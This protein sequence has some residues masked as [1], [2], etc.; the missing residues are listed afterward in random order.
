MVKLHVLRNGSP[1]QFYYLEVEKKEKKAPDRCFLRVPIN[2]ALNIND[3][4][5]VRTDEATPTYLFAGKIYEVQ[6][7]YGV[8]EATAYSYGIKADEIRV[9]PAKIYRNTSPESIARDLVT[10]FLGMQWGSTWSSGVTISS[11][12]AMGTVGENIR[13]LARMAGADYWVQTDSS[14]VTRFYF[15]PASITNLGLTFNVSGTGANAILKEYNPAGMEIINAVEVYGKT[16]YVTETYGYSSPLLS[17]SLLNFVKPCTSL[18]VTVRGRPAM[19]GRDYVYEPQDEYVKLPCMSFAYPIKGSPND[20][21]TVMINYQIDATEMAYSENTSSINTYGKRMKAYVYENAINQRDLQSIADKIVNLYG[22]PRRSMKLILPGINKNV[23]D[24]GYVRVTASHLGISNQVFVVRGVK[25]TYPPG[26]TELELGEFVPEIYDFEKEYPTLVESAAR[27]AIMINQKNA[28]YRLYMSG[29]GTTYYPY[30][31][32]PS[33]G[34]S[35]GSYARRTAYSINP[36]V[37]VSYDIILIGAY[38]RTYTRVGVTPV[39][40]GNVKQTVYSEPI[41]HL[42]RDYLSNPAY[43]NANNNNQITI[44]MQV[45]YEISYGGTRYLLAPKPGDSNKYFEV[46]I[47]N[48]KRILPSYPGIMAQ[49]MADVGQQGSAYI[50]YYW[51]VAAFYSSVDG[52]HIFNVGFEPV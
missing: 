13:K 9:F 44:K 25:W 17:W 29:D 49:V 50:Y 23:R 51:G 1:I 3:D 2:Q 11:Y 45:F 7:T 38:T 30:S 40:V 47:K 46:T 52:S 24:G 4:I 5:K 10:N 20:P 15:Q 18:S 31:F 28:L 34:E 14:G 16:K 6:A 43:L 21:T 22:S 19:E 33:L 12:E 32:K 48:V 27:S 8:K 26:V 37:W 36:Y 35:L 41:W 42:A 39:P